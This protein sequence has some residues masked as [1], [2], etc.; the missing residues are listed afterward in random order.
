MSDPKLSQAARWYLNEYG[1]EGALKRTA[2]LLKSCE[3]DDW[4]E[5]ASYLEEV[6]QEIYKILGWPK[7]TDTIH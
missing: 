2:S 6:Q 7:S 1:E 5:F 4:D 3:E